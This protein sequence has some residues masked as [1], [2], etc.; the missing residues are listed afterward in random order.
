MDAANLPA[1]DILGPGGGRYTLHEFGKRAVKLGKGGAGIV[2]SHPQFPG[3]AIKIYHDQH[4][5]E[6]HRDKV[7]AMLR[8]P[9]RAVRTSRNIVQLAWP[10]GEAVV[11]GQFIGFAMPLIDFRQAWTL[12]QAVYPP[13]RERHSIPERLQ[14]RL[15]AAR[16]LVAVLHALHEAGHYV[17]DLKPQNVLVYRDQVPD[18]AAHVILV[19]CD[20]FQ[21]RGLD[22]QRYDADLATA[23]FLHPAVARQHQDDPSFDKRKINDNAA[24]QDNFAL[25][26]ILFLLL[27]DGLH[28]MAGR[29]I[30]SSVPSDVATRLQHCGTYYPYRSSG[31]N[32]VLRPD[33]DSLHDWFDPALRV[34]FDQ[35]FSGRGEPPAQR[36]WLAVLDRLV[37]PDQRCANDA[38]H[39]KLGSQCGLCARAARAAPRQASPAPPPQQAVAVPA[40]VFAPAQAPPHPASALRVSA[41]RRGRWSRRGRI[42]LLLLPVAV[43][44]IGSVS[45][46]QLARGLLH[47][48]ENLPAAAASQASLAPG[49]VRQLQADLAALGYYRGAA[50]G[51]AG[52]ATA[53]AAAAFARAHGLV[54]SVPPGQG[55][56]PGQ[57]RQ[58]LAVAAKEK[59]AM[60]AVMPLAVPLT[61]EAD[62]AA[63]VRKPPAVM[64]VTG[65]P[66]V[67][68]TA[69][70]LVGGRSIALQGLRGLSGKPAQDLAAF[71]R[72]SGGRVSCNL[73][74][75]GYGCR[76]VTGGIDI[77]L[78]ALI[79]GAA[80]VSADASARQ[81]QAQK[82]A[83]AA[84]RGM[85]K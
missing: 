38:D 8:R 2:Y 80:T 73:L 28:P 78:T 32:A 7:R 45:K 84:H 19:D 6:A 11:K 25:A 31:G 63:A 27:N 37:Q 60:P 34:L 35:A 43:L 17:I 67:I 74:Q 47:R 39:W 52:A 23:D 68:D 71:I 59:A 9:P 48:L 72:N 49:Q 33:T 66:E 18:A 55:G 20:G 82:Q 85:W 24:K 61:A 81:A 79:N 42:A 15:Y 77:G 51:V 13:K 75:E 4:I 56:L 14:F 21:I 57:L 16:N 50:D 53:R 65:V 5:A 26:V 70:L 58:V 29:T 62:R 3:Q 69:H 10:D 46:S 22:G 64:P 40:A 36:E 30:A 83:Q 12:Q 1:L 54:L 44:A 41:G 76:T